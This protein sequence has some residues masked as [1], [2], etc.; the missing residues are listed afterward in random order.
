LKYCIT[1]LMNH[2]SD[3]LILGDYYNEDLKQVSYGIMR[4]SYDLQLIHDT[5]ISK[6]GCDHLY[7]GSMI[8]NQAGH[9][10]L[11]GSY[12]M[13]GQSQANSFF[14]EMTVDGDSVKEKIFDYLLP[15]S[16]II[17]L[18]GNHTYHATDP[19]SIAQLDT[20]FN[21][22]QFLYTAPSVGMPDYL[23]YLMSPKKVDNLSYLI[24]S[25]MY[26]LSP[27]AFDAA[28]G[29]FK[30]GIWESKL[31]FGSVDTSD[32]F[33]GMD[34]ITTDRI[35]TTITQL[36]PSN[37]DGANPTDQEFDPINNQMLLYSTNIAGTTNWI[38]RVSGLGF[39]RSGQPLATS[40]GGCLWLGYYWDWNHK[41]NPDYDL[42]IHKVNSDG[43]FFEN[44]EETE[45]SNR[46]IHVF[47]N[48]AGTY[49][50]VEYMLP[51][52]TANASLIVYSVSGIVVWKQDIK[53]AK[54]QI[55]IDLGGF[56]TG[57]YKV[58]LVDGNKILNSKLLT[59]S[60]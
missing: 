34:F 12:S 17:E 38:K 46:Y 23:Y 2:G 7:T 47:P 13:E 41:T 51:A 36:T 15:G 57:I 44:L 43:A 48:P 1:Q 35:Y 25:R 27:Y 28:W 56:N 22:N 54:D 32:F 39:M 9:L 40:D 14:R 21:F 5:V 16:N 33:M 52:K 58:S 31:Q 26:E 8:V 20:N 49:T 50:I 29:L 45:S 55:V 59:V 4:Y 37:L 24:G 42:I 3:F 18:T 60:K 11:P 6:P 53:K 19:W 30:N 10:V